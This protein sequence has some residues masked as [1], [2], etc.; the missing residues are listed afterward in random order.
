M[1]TSVP[2]QDADLTFGAGITLNSNEETGE[3]LANPVEADEF[4]PR[5]ANDIEGLL[6]LGRL[7]HRCE[8]FGH[9]FILKTLTRGERLATTL[10]THEY[11]DSLG[12]ADALQT[13]LLAAAIV[14]VDGRPVSVP[15]S[16]DE[17]EPLPRIRKNFTIVQKWY[18]P[19]LEAL[20]AEYGNLL[21]RQAGAF[22][23]LSGK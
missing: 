15:L 5:H 19:I 2:E 8:V 13:A 9:T 16:P 14:S 23:E 7:T 4:D 20:Y 21:L 3:L 18:D 10:V 6:F 12:V 22:A 1:E 17:N 11:E